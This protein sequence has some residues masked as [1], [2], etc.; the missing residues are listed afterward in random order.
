MAQDNDGSMAVIISLLV[1]VL[2]LVVITA[3]L[4][5]VTPFPG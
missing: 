2:F 1:I 4:P 3:A 5:T